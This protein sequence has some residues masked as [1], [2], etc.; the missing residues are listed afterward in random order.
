MAGGRAGYLGAFLVG[1]AFA[2][3]WSPCIGPVLAG[4]LTMAAAGGSTLQAAVLLL[5]YSAGLAI[6]FL[7]AALA[8]DRFLAWSAR[9]RHSWLPV[10]ER[11]SGGGSCWPSASCSSPASSPGWR[12]GWRPDA[13]GRPD[14]GRRLQPV[15][16]SKKPRRPVEVVD[17]PGPVVVVVSGPG[18]VS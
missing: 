3:G 17:S 9:L 4:I 15:G 12:P 7:A 8:L 16:S 5:A 13:G 11:V 10:A 14:A 2:A 1:I 18:S 6:P